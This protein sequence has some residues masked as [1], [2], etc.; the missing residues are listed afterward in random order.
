MKTVAI[1][2]A[3]SFWAVLQIHAAFLEGWTAVAPREEI[4]PQFEQSETGGKS[5]HGVLTIRADEREGLHGWWQKSFPV[6][7]RL[8]YRFAACRHAS[9]GAMIKERKSNGIIAF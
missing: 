7:G 8:F 2:I 6:K 5:G 9:F 1:F 4:R 3:C